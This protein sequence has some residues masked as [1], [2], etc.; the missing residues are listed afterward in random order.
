MPPGQVPRPYP[1]FDSVEFAQDEDDVEE[2]E[3]GVDEE[4]AEVAVQSGHDL[5][6]VAPWR[7]GIEVCLGRLPVRLVLAGNDLDE[8]GLPV[9]DDGVIGRLAVLRLVVELEQPGRRSAFG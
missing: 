2:D 3:D 6:V 1:L 8:G 5:V 7:D 9:V 4:D